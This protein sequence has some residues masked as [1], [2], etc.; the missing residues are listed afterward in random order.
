VYP[1]LTATPWHDPGDFPIV[2]AL[3][4]ACDGIAAELAA[5]D[6]EAFHRESEPLARDGDWDVLMLYERGQK[7]LENCARLPLTTELV[8]RFETVKTFVGLVYF[9]RMRPGTHIKPHRGP[10]NLR[11]RCHLPLVVPPGD[12]ALRVGAHARRWERGRCLTFD[13]FFEHE[14]WNRTQGERIVLVV[15]LW[16]PELS[17]AEIGLLTGLQDRIL[18]QAR[19]L[20]RYWENNARARGRVLSGPS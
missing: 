20:Q 7:Q 4:G 6:A 1:G 8:E 16:H 12:C 17:A 19:N 11:V 18:W 9:S 13:D 5:V 15:D 3:E 10:T 14:A 2:T